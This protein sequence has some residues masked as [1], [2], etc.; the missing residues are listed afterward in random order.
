MILPALD[1]GSAALAN[2]TLRASLDELASGLRLTGTVALRDTTGAHAE[3]IETL[4]KTHPGAYA[5]E[6]VKDAETA[7]T[8]LNAG[9]TRVTVPSDILLADT[10]FTTIGLPKDRV[11]AEIVV[12]RG[13]DLAAL[14]AAAAPVAGGFHLIFA[15][16]PDVVALAAFAK[17]QPLKRVSAA[18]VITTGSQVATLDKAGVF[19]RAGAPLLDGTL[20]L[21]DALAACLKTDRTDGLWS[22]VIVDEH[23]TALGLAYSDLESLRTAVGKRVG[24][25]HSRSRNNLWIKGATSG[26]TQQLLGVALDCDRDALRFTVRQ[27]DPGFCHENVWTCWGQSGGLPALSR[28]LASRAKDAPS[29]SYTHRLLNDPA[30][31]ASKLREEAGELIDASA[32][33]D[34]QEVV[35][36][37]ADV[38]YFTLVHLAKHGVSLAEVEQHLDAR[39]LKVTRRK[40]D[41]KPGK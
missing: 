27:V 26:A 28:L 23:G 6:S 17:T 1:F 19:A 32:Q 21:A 20:S 9:A 30:L 8:L 39:H 13:D 35:W 37:A 15:G 3:L 11:W 29:G 4:V 14:A 10:G 7:L 34:R 2:A 16:E 22:T 36:E 41:A 5:V 40:G 18:G 25:Y 31:L 24:A 33:N 12:K 38:I